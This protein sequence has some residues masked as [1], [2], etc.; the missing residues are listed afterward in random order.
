MTLSIWDSLEEEKRNKIDGNTLVLIK[1][2]CIEYE[3]A[4]LKGKWFVVTAKIS[5]PHDSE[6][7]F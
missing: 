2:R 5:G 3:M 7:G 1:S 4:A 6:L